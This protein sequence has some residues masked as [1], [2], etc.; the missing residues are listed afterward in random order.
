[1]VLLSL[2][3]FLGGT[4]ISTRLPDSQQWMLFFSGLQIALILLFMLNQLV[5]G[6]RSGYVWQFAM[7]F[8]ASLRWG[9]TPNLGAITATNVINTDLL[10]NVSAVVIGIII[11]AFAGVL[12]AN[13]VR[14]VHSLRWPLLWL[15]VLLLLA[16]LSG[17]LM[18]V[19]MKLQVM[20]LTKSLLS[21]VAKVTNASGLI[22]YICGGL[23]LLSALIYLLKIVLPR[24]AAQVEPRPI[25]HR[26]SVAHY[27]NS[28]RVLLMTLVLVLITVASQ[29]YWDKIASQPPRLSEAFPVTLNADGLVHIPLEQVKDGKLHR[30][31]WVADDGKAV[32]FFVIN[33]YPDKLRLGVVFDACLLCGDQGYVMEGNQVICVACDVRIFIPSIGKPGGCNP[34]PIDEWEMTE[35]DLVISKKSLESGLNYFST[36]ITLEVTDPVDGSKLTN[37]KAEHR[38]NFAGKTYFFSNAANYEAF[39]ETPEKFVKEGE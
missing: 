11:V 34:V 35:T 37:T 2:L 16:P 19:L 26:K 38:Y 5:S 8:I 12:L 31:V 21:Y 6:S 9:K 15:L 20:D 1:M 22:N 3:G 29:L 23:L 28:R 10:I 32:R 13:C 24:R 30:F 7:I 36:I 4:I 39:R 18:L 27:Q 17:E 33:R 14:Q 25:E